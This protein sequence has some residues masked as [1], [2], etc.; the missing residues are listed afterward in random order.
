MKQTAVEW[1]FKHLEGIRIIDGY[2]W[3]KLQQAFEQAKAMEKEQIENA[4]IDGG[5]NQRTAVKYY[6]E[7][8]KKK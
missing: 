8:F 5:K 2:E 7:T 1:F 6:N 4:H 3:I